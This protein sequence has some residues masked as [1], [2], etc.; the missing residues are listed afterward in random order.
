M[1]NIK[2]QVILFHTHTKNSKLSIVFSQ[3]IYIYFKVQHKTDDRKNFS[4]RPTFVCHS[5][6]QCL[7]DTA[8]VLQGKLQA[9]QIPDNRHQLLCL[10][11]ST[12]LLE[13][14]PFYQVMENS[15]EL[16]QLMYGFLNYQKMLKL[17]I[18]IMFQALRDYIYTYICMF[19]YLL[20][21]DQ[22]TE[23]QRE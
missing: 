22:E 20:F 12:K 3:K 13:A 7:E 17:I 1:M 23:A 21:E 16:W 6:R 15:T 2:I 10:R 8:S 5:C 18:T 4:R 11:T 9:H 19:Y 14:E